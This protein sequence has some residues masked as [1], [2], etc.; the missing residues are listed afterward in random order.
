MNYIRELNAFRDWLMLNHL[1]TSGVA[2]W[3]TLMAVNNMA[4]WK[5][6]FTVPNPTLMQ[7]TKL[8]KQ[9]LAD[10][11]SELKN[12]KLIDYR[13]GNR[14]QAG[15]YKMISLVNSFDQTLDPILDQTVDQTLD[16]SADQLLTIIKHKQEETKQDN[17]TSPDPFRLFESEGFGT[18]SPFIADNIQDLVKT[19]G[20]TWVCEAMRESVIQGKRKL[21][22]VHGI[23][24]SWAADGMKRTG[25]R[26]KEDKTAGPYVPNAEE[27][28]KFLEEQERLEREYRE[29][30]GVGTA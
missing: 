18:I 15:S 25:D 22:Y 27:S 30:R 26:R 3:Y 10:A 1:N 16:P 6:W 5:E 12:K 23:L 24:K 28:R 4:G 2:L 7:L 20:E 17:T 8:S 19:Y 14:K 13:P 21:S 29:G 11:R 9:G